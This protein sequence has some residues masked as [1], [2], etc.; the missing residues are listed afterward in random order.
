MIFF[1][2]PTNSLGNR[3][4]VTLQ[5]LIGASKIA[6]QLG[7]NHKKVQ[8]IAWSEIYDD[9][10]D[11]LSDLLVVAED[12]PVCQLMVGSAIKLTGCDPT[13]DSEGCWLTLM[14]WAHPLVGNI[15]NSPN[16]RSSDWETQYNTNWAMMNL[17]DAQT[18]GNIKYL[19]QNKMVRLLGAPRDQ[20]RVVNN[21]TELARAF[22]GELTTYVTKKVEKIL[23]LRLCLSDML[24]ESQRDLIVRLLK[25]RGKA[26]L[27]EAAK[28]GFGHWEYTR[29]Y[30]PKIGVIA[31]QESREA[32]FQGLIDGALKPVTMIRA[33]DKL[34][35]EC[36]GQ[37]IVL[38]PSI[39]CA[40]LINDFR[41]I[42]R[43]KTPIFDRARPVCIPLKGLIPRVA[44]QGTKLKPSDSKRLLSE[45]CSVVRESGY[46]D[47]VPASPK[48]LWS[49]NREEYHLP[50]MT[51]RLHLCPQWGGSSGHTTG[52]LAYW[53]GVLS[54]SLKPE[55]GCVVATSLFMLWRLY[56][57]K[58]ISAMHCMVETLEA[59]L[60]ESVV[61]D[62]AGISL[63]PIVTS[64]EFED[65]WSLLVSCAV[66]GKPISK[67]QRLFGVNPI[68]VMHTA[69]QWV[70]GDK[71]GPK[72]VN[73]LD[74]IILLDSRKVSESF[75]LPEWSR[76]TD[77][78]SGT[79]VRAVGRG[80]ITTI[81]KLL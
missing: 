75:F 74:Q 68:S 6:P 31:S 2:I 1:V 5:G 49:W 56:Y 81:G 7:W 4:S 72:L 44:L 51:Y 48:L 30:L 47:H 71:R 59:T 55:D 80:K 22:V 32:M 3:S 63:S 53:L 77:D 78:V 41:K 50:V 8:L 28:S 17:I 19:A 61:G 20:V 21:L 35:L 24:L 10:A 54:E 37:W 43:I 33:K 69:L 79:E 15:V 67:T 65:P 23:A 16:L 12:D 9:L 14:H 52:A 34:V 29:Y 38:P 18:R 60:T 26:L 46:K 42:D 27:V 64:D 73:L 58:R 62:A 57:D 40:I 25:V 11:L 13:D 39:C 76:E 70:C 45:P 36:L 66:T